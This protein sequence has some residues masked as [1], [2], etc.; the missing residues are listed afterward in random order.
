MGNAPIMEIE[1]VPG[2]RG[3]ATPHGGRRR[4]SARGRMPERRVRESARAHPAGATADAGR[5]V[6]DGSAVR[7][8]RRA[9]DSGFDALH[10]EYAR[11]NPAV[12]ARSAA[13]T[14]K[15]RLYRSSRWYGPPEHA[16]TDL[17]HPRRG[18]PRR[19]LGPTIPLLSPVRERAFGL[20]Y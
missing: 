5:L 12:G 14:L 20:P 4:G 8:A 13:G 9:T 16:P 17:F 2:H 3:V 6:F 7:A 11:N 19:L 1:S 15:N 18:G 10:P